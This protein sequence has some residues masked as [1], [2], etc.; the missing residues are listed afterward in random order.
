M[1]F[2]IK[3]LKMVKDMSWITKNQWLKILKVAIWVGL[4]FGLAVLTA[5]ITKDYKWVASAP[6]Y[7]VIIVAISQLF[8]TETTASLSQVPPAVQP[9]VYQVVSQVEA[10]E[11]PS[12]PPTPATQK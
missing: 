1:G 8:Q 4:S 10:L 5:W 12:N 6:A 3:V 11:P 9:V 7:N 2:N